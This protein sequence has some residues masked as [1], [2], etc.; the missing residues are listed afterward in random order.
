MKKR[1]IAL[2]VVAWPFL[3]LAVF[4]ARFRRLPPVGEL[5]TFVPTGVLG[6]LAVHVLV[7][8]SRS[9]GQTTAIVLGAALLTPVALLGNL[10]GGLLGP[11]AITVYGLA[12]L[13]VGASCGWLVG[14]RFS[15]RR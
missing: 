8:R 1:W 7:S 13:V 2:V 6:A 5:L 12:P 9:A 11:L 4:L 14:K 3:H 10:Y 15:P